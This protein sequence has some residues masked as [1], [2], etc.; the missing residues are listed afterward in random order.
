ME[1]KEEE[2]QKKEEE[3]QRLSSTHEIALESDEL[4]HLRVYM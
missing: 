2:D 3:K 4:K 1:Q